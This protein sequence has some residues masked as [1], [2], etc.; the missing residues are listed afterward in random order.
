MVA[1][2]ALYIFLFFILILIFKAI[3]INEVKEIVRIVKSSF[4]KSVY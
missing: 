4:I 2:T 3:R 1:L